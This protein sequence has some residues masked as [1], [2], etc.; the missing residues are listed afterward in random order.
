MRLMLLVKWVNINM[1][2]LINDL[3]NL[4]YNI[5]R[6]FTSD[7]DLINELYN[8]GVLGVYEAYDNYDKK[9]NTKFSSYAYMYIYGKMY[10]YINFNHSIK[11]NK[12]A[13]KL[14]KLIIK[15]KEYLS[16]VNFKEP[17]IKDIANYL[18]LDETM[19]EN[20]MII[21]QNA[22]SLD[23][24]Y[25]SYNMTSFIDERKNKNYEEISDL[26]SALDDEQRKVIF[27]KYYSGYSQ[28]EIAKLMNMSQSSVS[29]CEKVSIEKMRSRSLV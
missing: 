3:S 16:Q 11:P 22:L 10:E 8:Q 18:K 14:Y 15:T 25:D 5:A 4:I 9:S 23:Y 12:D 19:V 20:T 27:Y 1:E 29:R 24:E 17:T 26:L 2:D 21:F 13:I 7:K 6:K 28:C